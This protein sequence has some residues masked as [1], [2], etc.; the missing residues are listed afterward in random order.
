MRKTIYLTRHG[1]TRFNVEGRTQGS[2][3]SPLT[4]LGIEQAHK[5]RA[6]FEKNGITFDKVY[7][8]TQ[9]RAVDTAEIMG[10]TTDIIRLKGLK[11][12][13]FGVFEAHPEHL[14]DGVRDPKALS[15]EDTLVPFNGESRIMVGKRVEKALK[16]A[17]E[18]E[19]NTI[20]AVSHGGAMWSFVLTT[21]I[22]EIPKPQFNNC[23]ILHLEYEDGKF[24]FIELIDVIN[25]TI[26]HEIIEQK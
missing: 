24:Y 16:E 19:G 11:E 7:S 3:D 15:Y 26:R 22:D 13:D 4:P 1:Q 6:Y 20:L 25:D 10:N 23:C 18:Q 17:M 8:S 21:I 12:W 5:A 9:E 14:K 2:S